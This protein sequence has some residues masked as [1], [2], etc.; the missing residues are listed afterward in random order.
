MLFLL[1]LICCIGGAVILAGITTAIE[2]WN[3]K[4][5][6]VEEKSTPCYIRSK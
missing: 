3:D 5:P 2:N 6:V 1:K 4:H